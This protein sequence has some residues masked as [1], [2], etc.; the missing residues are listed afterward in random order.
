[1]EVLNILHH[2]S[3]NAILSKYKASKT[4]KR[5]EKS[6]LVGIMPNSHKNLVFIT[7]F[8]TIKRKGM[9]GITIVNS[10][11]NALRNPSFFT[12]K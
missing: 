11:Y 2:H 8:I 1:M 7:K 3:T 6:T 5:E 10:S 9:S 4:I 12:I